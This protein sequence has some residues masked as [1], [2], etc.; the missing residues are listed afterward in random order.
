[1]V[2]ELISFPTSLSTLRLIDGDYESHKEKR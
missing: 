2:T 1:M